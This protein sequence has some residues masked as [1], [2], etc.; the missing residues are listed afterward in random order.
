MKHHQQSKFTLIELLVVIAIIAILAAI[1][2]PALNSARESGRAASCTN[3]L[4]QI[5]TA[6]DMYSNDFDDYFIPHAIDSVSSAGKRITWAS[7]I[8]SPY[9]K[10]YIPYDP[11]LCPSAG[12]P[13][14]IERWR[15]NGT[16]ATAA[17]AKDY[18]WSFS[19]YGYNAHYPGGA[20]YQEYENGKPPK[21][22]RAGNVS[23]LLL[24]VD[25]QFCDSSTSLPKIA[26][27]AENA[28]FSY[29]WPNDNISNV[30]WATGTVWARHGNSA[31]A[32]FA[33]GHVEKATGSGA[34]KLAIRASL[35]AK[36]GALE[37]IAHSGTKWMQKLPTNAAGY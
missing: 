4:K 12:I 7:L 11:L 26:E 22:H 29:V 31:N 36:G 17:A 25:S 24:F 1:L 5:G 30:G 37:G 10:N 35:Y 15:S 2:L 19:S 27:G 8:A 9:Y 23:G 13:L 6:S 16:T 18:I 32:A 21:R 14:G 33:D 20:I 3:N 28:G 34:D